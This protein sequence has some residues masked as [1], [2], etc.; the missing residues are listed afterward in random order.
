MN[1]TNFEPLQSKSSN[2]QP[3]VEYENL[4]IHPSGRNELIARYIK[5]R[6]GKT[7][8]RK[9][10]PINYY[11]SARNHQ[12]QLYLRKRSKKVLS[13]NCTY[14]HQH[15]IRFCWRSIFG[16][17]TLDFQVSSHI[18]VLA[19]RKLREIQAKLKVSSCSFWEGPVESVRKPTRWKNSNSP[20]LERDCKMSD[21]IQ[22]VFPAGWLLVIFA[23]F[24]AFP[25]F[26]QPSDP[27]C[28]QSSPPPNESDIIILSPPTN[29]PAIAKCKFVPRD[30]IK[31]KAT[32][33]PTLKK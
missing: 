33:V 32:L 11:I 1:E 9:Q 3:S 24:P 29:Y 2:I 17:F 31:S 16:E 27:L 22:K 7:R 19:R 13:R 14:S 30:L 10:V 8:T 4:D 20:T 21:F 6:T 28:I 12:L 18:Q 23:S 5:L 15:C 25:P 26:S